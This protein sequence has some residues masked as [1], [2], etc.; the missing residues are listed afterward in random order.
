MYRAI[1][2]STGKRLVV[3]GILQGNNMNRIF[4]VSIA[5]HEN[6]VP[7]L[8]TELFAAGY[9]EGITQ[10]PTD[11]FCYVIADTKELKVT[12]TELYKKRFANYKNVTIFVDTI[13]NFK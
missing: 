6:S 4:M 11:V 7:N 2:T 10:K 12:L 1:N 8:S 13:D 5:G 9:M 3:D